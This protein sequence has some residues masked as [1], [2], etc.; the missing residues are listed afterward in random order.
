M[1]NSRAYY[2]R[3][4]T[5]GTPTVQTLSYPP[6]QEVKALHTRR[7]GFK[8]VIFRIPDHYLEN[9]ISAN[10]DHS[11]LQFPG[12]S[13]AFQLWIPVSSKGHPEYWSS[14]IYTIIT[15]ILQWADFH[16]LIRLNGK[17]LTQLPEKKSFLLT[18]FFYF[19]NAIGSSHPA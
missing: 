8:A 17:Q 19:K 16:S 4:W 18:L 11:L 15:H 13:T 6:K 2:I 9:P 1:K 14:T 12:A 7:P 5:S 3:F 10:S